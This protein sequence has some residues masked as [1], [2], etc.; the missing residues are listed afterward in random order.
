MKRGGSKKNKCIDIELN[1]KK[2]ANDYASIRSSSKSLCS[3]VNKF[4]APE[5]ERERRQAPPNNL[6]SL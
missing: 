2:R 1:F 6:I 4:T 3:C 5:K